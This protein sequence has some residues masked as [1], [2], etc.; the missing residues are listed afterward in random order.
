MNSKF[1]KIITIPGRSDYNNQFRL[2]EFYNCTMELG[3]TIRSL[4]KTSIDTNQIHNK[5]VLLKPNWV[6]HSLA[7]EDDICLRTNDNFTIAVLAAILEMKP[8]EVVI[9]DAP[10]QGCKWDKMISNAFIGSI[11]SLSNSHNIPVLVRDFRRRTY[12]FSENAPVAELKPLTDYIIFD[13]G[14]ESFLEPVTQTD[15]NRFRVTNYDPSRML[16]AHSQGIHKYCISKE[17]FNTDIV[18]S[19]PK[20]KTHQKTGITGALKILVGING[21]KDFLPHHRIGGTGFDGDCYPGRSYIRYFSELLLDKANHNQGTKRFWLWQKLSSLLWM[22]SFP[23]PKHSLEAGWYGNDTTWRMV[24]DLNRI[25]EFGRSDGTISN[26]PQRQIYSICDGIIG[27]Q[28]DGP[29]F[30]QP[31]P[32]GIVSVTNNALVNDKAMAILMGFPPLKIPLLSSQPPTNQD[33]N[34]EISLNGFKIQLED[35]VPYAVRANPPRGWVD[36]FNAVK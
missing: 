19:I 4:V 6:R 31:L 15:Q 34:C 26:M 11:D 33:T 16:M 7:P 36:Y 12:T 10:I 28:G 1:L 13:L 17:F 14:K 5:R 2:G 30:P 21:D 20:V 24:M 27:G 23:G 22:L 18:I 32:L 29:L 3:E 8:S 35:L 25:A 9:G